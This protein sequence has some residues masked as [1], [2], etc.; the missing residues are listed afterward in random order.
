MRTILIS[1]LLLGSTA[2]A[3]AG[4][5]TGSLGVGAEQQL[6]GISGVSLDYDLGK[7]NVGGLLGLAERRDNNVNR[8]FT[9]VY[10]GGDFFFRVASTATTDFSV[11]GQIGIASVPAINMTPTHDRDF[12]LYL[13]P[14]FRIRAFVATNVALSFF[15][16]F[17]IGVAD[18][19][20]N[21]SI[22]GDL[23]GSAGVHYYF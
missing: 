2:L 15:G 16:G 8:S 23:T 12:D 11:G 21:V 13:E 6:S 4:G 1:A 14:G 18:A 19:N 17:S 22:G 3:H 20:N 10:L 9:S 5:Q 7:F